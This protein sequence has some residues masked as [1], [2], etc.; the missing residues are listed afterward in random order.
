[1]CC[2][3]PSW[4]LC[5]QGMAQQVLFVCF[6]AGCRAVCCHTGSHCLHLAL[7]C[8]QE[9]VQCSGLLHDKVL[10]AA[11]TTVG[12]LKQVPTVNSRSCLLLVAGMLV[13][14]QT[15]KTACCLA[16]LSTDCVFVA[17]C[18]RIATSVAAIGQSSCVAGCEAAASQHVKSKRANFQ[19]LHQALVINGWSLAHC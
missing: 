8:S 7:S 11:F 18:V 4:P 16:G 1:V 6:I 10:P 13:P 3:W 14:Q 17:C 9:A 12:V 19:G 15:I 2:L 5:N